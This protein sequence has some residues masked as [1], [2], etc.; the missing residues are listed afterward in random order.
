MP[1]QCQ[2]AVGQLDNVRV[3]GRVR[4]RVTTVLM[5]QE[6]VSEEDAGLVTNTIQ[7]VLPVG[8]NVAEEA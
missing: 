6:E 3:R 8:I 7:W 4:G 1:V 5:E 2:H